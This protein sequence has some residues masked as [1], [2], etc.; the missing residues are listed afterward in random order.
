VLEVYDSEFFSLEQTIFIG[1]THI[2]MLYVEFNILPT[3]SL[4]FEDEG[5]ST[6]FMKGN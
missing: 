6:I 4:S 2:N 5:V 3:R 1:F